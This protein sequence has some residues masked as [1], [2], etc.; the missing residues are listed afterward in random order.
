MGQPQS[1]ELALAAVSQLR[2]QL[3]SRAAHAARLLGIGGATGLSSVV[4]ALSVMSGLLGDDHLLADAY[5]A[6]TLIS[7]DLIAADNRRDVIA[8]SAGAILCLLHLYSVAGADRGARPRGEM[9]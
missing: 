2:A 7:D 3:T 9:W 5:H 4:Y 8:G 6:A 1:A